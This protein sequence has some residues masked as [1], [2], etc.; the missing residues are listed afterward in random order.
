MRSEELPSIRA[1]VEIT[2]LTYSAANK[3]LWLYRRGEI[4]RRGL[5]ETRAH[6]LR[7]K[8]ANLWGIPDGGNTEWLALNDDTPHD[9]RL[10]NIKG[11]TELER[12]YGL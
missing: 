11:R 5:L 10:A 12:R 3:R 2:G 6:S 7:R 8:A 4:D 1:L 9:E